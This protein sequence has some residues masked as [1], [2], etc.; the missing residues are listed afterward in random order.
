VGLRRLIV[1]VLLA[2]CGGEESTP[3]VT[4]PGC[5]TNEIALP[6]GSC[7][8]PGVPAGG[9]GTGFAHDGEGG[10][11]PILPPTCPRGA[12]AVPGD[13]ACRPVMPCAPG[14]W[15]DIARGADTEHVDVLYTAADADGSEAKPWPTIGAAIAAAAP[16]STVAVAPGT[17]VEDVAVDKPV[18]LAGVCPELVEV[19]GSGAEL[20]TV[21]VVTG[22]D[23]AELRGI[24]IGGPAVGIFVSG[25]SNVLVD[26]VW[27]REME[28]CVDI[29]STYGPTS[30]TVVGSLFESCSVTGFFVGGAVASLERSVVRG[31]NGSA[32]GIQMRCYPNTG[33]E[34]DAR[35]SATVHASVFELAL[36]GIFVAGSDAV[37]EDSVSRASNAGIEVEGCA[38][39]DGCDPP[40]RASVTI[41]RS[42]VSESN[43]HA[44]HI[45][46]SDAA[47]EA[48]VMRDTVAALPAPGRGIS[49]EP[50][51]PGVCLPGTGGRLTLSRSSIARTHQ[52][53]VFAAGSEASLDG[54]MVR[55]TFADAAGLGGRGLAAQIACTDAGCEPA[56]VAD[57]Q[58]QRTLIAGSRDMAIYASHGNVTV[59]TSVIRDTAVNDA[60]S[61]FG[62]GLTV[63]RE[64]GFPSSAT[65]TGLRILHSARAGVSV[66]GTT[67]SLKGLRVAC[68][69]FD[70]TSQAY[71]GGDPSFDDAGDNLCGCPD[72]VE[73]C[74]VITPDL[75]PP[76]PL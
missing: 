54:V 11:T 9:C 49:V 14:K 59:D 38:P 2:G 39:V 18:H 73:P 15:G 24:A 48:T 42:L 21:R 65:V 60:T 31:T 8:A 7:F 5:S 33:C 57:M 34:G 26:R 72:P 23:G 70:L 40:T 67:V 3:V 64:D 30:A 62:D 44:I 32:L 17:Y 25:A 71:D 29:E 56:L 13:E 1:A 16:G 19:V 66:F 43:D 68:A 63:L 6:D 55:D 35:A 69:A 46:G 76:S 27:V 28:R 20:G 37:V 53:G 4:D 22:A 41:A 45:G 50:L 74:K 36:A 10:C 52:V 61:T 51:C 12:M 47:V 58:I 75:V